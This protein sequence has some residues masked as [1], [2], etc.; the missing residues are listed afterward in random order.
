MIFTGI[1]SSGLV[2]AE[3]SGFLPKVGSAYGMLFF[4]SLGGME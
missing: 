4:F 2:G 3:K 1:F